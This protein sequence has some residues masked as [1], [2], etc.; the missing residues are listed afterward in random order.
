MTHKLFSIVEFLGVDLDNETLRDL[1]IE[2]EN[3]R[4]AEAPSNRLLDIVTSTIDQGKSYYQECQHI[5]EILVPT[6]DRSTDNDSNQNNVNNHQPS[7]SA[8]IG[9]SISKKTKI[10]R[11]ETN[12]E[13]DR[14][15]KT[16]FKG[17]DKVSKRLTGWIQGDYSFASELFDEMVELRRNL[18]KMK[19]KYNEITFYDDSD[20]ED[21]EEVPPDQ[22]EAELNAMKS[23][24]QPEEPIITEPKDPL[25]VKKSE[26]KKFKLSEIAK[27]ES[28]TEVETHRT[29]GIKCANN[30]F[31]TTEDIQELPEE[32][33]KRLSA[34]YYTIEDIASTEDTK[35]FINQPHL[36]N[37]SFGK[38]LSIYIFILSPTS[39]A[40]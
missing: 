35:V 23:L 19:Q 9:I 25:P 1:E 29:G 13:L 7:T 5:F 28:E 16:V 21:F 14:E 37:F 40:V 17:C 22:N 4:Q 34:R 15:L 2:I 24:F 6:D 27:L 10:K 8:T 31:G 3:S 26:K 20:E 11:D 32:S 38:L 30:V 36:E 33:A 39:N 18:S 12:R